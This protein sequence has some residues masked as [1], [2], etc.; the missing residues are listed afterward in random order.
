MHTH[1]DIKNT[2]TN[3]HTH[4]HTHMYTSARERICDLYASTKD[5]Q[6]F[7]FHSALRQSKRMYLRATDECF[8]FFFLLIE[9]IYTCYLKKY[10]EIDLRLRCS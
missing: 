7:Y 9:C 5:V 2:H 6:W 3:T 1:I 4:T 8:F 10:S